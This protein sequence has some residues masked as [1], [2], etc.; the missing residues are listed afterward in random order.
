MYTYGVVVI[1]L[2]LNIYFFYPAWRA[3]MK[4]G[5]SVEGVISEIK[6]NNLIQY[7]VKA[8]EDFEKGKNLE[9]VW[10]DVYGAVLNSFNHQ[11]IGE[12][13]SEEQYDQDLI[14]L[15]SHELFTYERMAQVAAYRA[16]VKGDLDA[17]EI[18]D[19]FDQC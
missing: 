12:D 6:K 14:N 10:R 18:C 8:A 19:L 2:I 13:V 3:V 7:M 15:E 9:S 17:N 1:L 16:R 11:K 4:D 5:Q